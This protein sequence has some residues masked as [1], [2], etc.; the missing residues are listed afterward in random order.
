M[1]RFETF[2]LS[3]GD[4]ETALLEWLDR[5]GHKHLAKPDFYFFTNFTT[6]TPTGEVSIK[7]KIK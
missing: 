5:R 7:V 6:E 1:K 4:V 2:R 3:K